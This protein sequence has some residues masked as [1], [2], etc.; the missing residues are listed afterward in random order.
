MTLDRTPL[1]SRPDFCRALPAWALAAGLACVGPTA[2]VAD[3]TPADLLEGAFVG[4]ER[5]IA[6][7]LLSGHREDPTALPIEKELDRA[8]GYVPGGGRID[9]AIAPILR[10]DRNING[11]MASDR[12]E[13]GPFLFTFPEEALA[14]EGV[15]I[16]A[17]GAMRGVTNI[18]TATALT[19]TASLELGYA[20]EHQLGTAKA[21]LGGCVSHRATKRVF[22]DGCVT[23]V[24][25]KR[26]LV[27]SSSLISSLEVGRTVTAPGVAAHLALEAGRV[28]RWT[29]YDF[30]VG[31]PFIGLSADIVT[32]AWGS[33]GISGQAFAEREDYT[34]PV[35]RIA[36]D[37]TTRA[38][39][40]PLRVAAYRE[41][42]R[43]GYHLGE[44]RSALN[45]GASVTIGL[46]DAVSVVLGYERVDARNAFYDEEGVDM[47]FRAEF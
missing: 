37:V 27:E 33:V 11:G 42:A 36:A 41:R 19:G 26:D 15:V 34:L 29:D 12:L 31:Q 10:Y 22:V 6:L 28:D 38:F 4:G 24:H 35:A 9:F 47:Q 21:V 32:G 5:K 18:A 23:G 17:R 46:T 13:V 1:R 25:D 45:V 20:P 8:S 43:G 3:A 14:K 39:D 16:G 44:S 7:G 40:R 2:A 30:S